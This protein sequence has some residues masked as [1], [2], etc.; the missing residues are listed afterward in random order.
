MVPFILPR[1]HI[2]EFAATLGSSSLPAKDADKPKDGKLHALENITDTPS[3]LT[4]APVTTAIS[5][6]PP[7]IL[8]GK[9]IEEVV[10]KWTADLDSHVREF[11]KSAGE[12]AVW[13]RALMENGNNVSAHSTTTDDHNRGLNLACSWLQYT[14]MF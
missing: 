8:R 6:P 9:T 12:V 14:A 3:P 5:V 2:I 10:N 1:T 11:N 13:D 7:S 4:V